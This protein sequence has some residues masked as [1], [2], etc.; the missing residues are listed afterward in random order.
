MHSV[1]RGQPIPS[2]CLRPP[3]RPVAARRE[4]PF[5]RKGDDAA[6]I[7]VSDSDA[8][9]DKVLIRS[10]RSL[11]F[12]GRHALGTSMRRWGCAGRSYPRIRPREVQRYDGGSEAHGASKSHPSVDWHHEAQWDWSRIGMGLLCARIFAFSPNPA[13]R[14]GS[15]TAVARPLQG[16]LASV[17]QSAPEP[18]ALADHL[19]QLECERLTN[20]LSQGLRPSSG[21]ILPSG[22]PAPMLPGDAGG[23]D[24][25]PRRAARRQIRTS[26]QS[27]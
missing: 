6:L 22:H 25:D 16:P 12:R 27:R 2:I 9:S 5:W 24:M 11:V 15:V 26:C 3:E 1:A 10:C 23:C 19:C 4:S 14:L 21:P 8:P 7:R 13:I 18:A 20:R 17:S